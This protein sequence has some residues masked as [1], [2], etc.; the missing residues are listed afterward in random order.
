VKVELGGNDICNRTSTGQ[1]YDD[2]TWRTAVRAGLDTLT[3]RLPDGS[4]VLLV[5]VP[6]V[7]K[8]Y[9]AGV[10]KSAGSTRVNCESFWRSYDVCQIATRNDIYGGEYLDARLLKVADR[11]GRYNEILR[12][13]AASYNLRASQTRVEVVAE[14]DGIYTLDT[15]EVGNYSFNKDEINGGDCFHPSILGQNRVST[16]VWGNDPNRVRR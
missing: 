9:A 7:Q 3:N 1:M 12:Q 15:P 14:T 10:D 6:Q 5:G 8:L 13:E 16:V 11:Q 4:T 2:D